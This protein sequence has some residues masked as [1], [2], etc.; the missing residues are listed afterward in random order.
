MSKG[1]FKG[2][3]LLTLA[4]TMVF[5]ATAA[6][7]RDKKGDASDKV[8][9]VTVTVDAKKGKARSVNPA[10]FAVYKGDTKQEIVGVQGPAEAPVNV[11][12]LIQDGLESRVGNELATV[13]E[14]IGELPEG[15]QVMVGYLRSTGLR[16]VQPF[17]TDIKRAQKAIRLPFSNLDQ[18]SAPFI[19]VGE[20]LKTFEGLT[21]RNQV[22]LIS[23]GLELNRDFSSASPA[24]NLDLD[25]AISKAQRLGVP[26]WSIFANAPGRF[27]QLSIV[28]SYGQGSLNRLSDETGGEAFFG[29]TSYVT[30]DHAFD[31]I[32]ENL[33]NQY[34][35]A[36]RGDGKGDLDVTLDTPGVKV[37]HAK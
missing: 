21:G 32:R 36:F 11:A 15:S 2:I 4:S 24:N 29:G 6:S 7:A 8:Q 13:K 20:A 35:I 23:N 17:T 28:V 16:T 22:V 3:A 31:T 27:G 12:I 14:F 5:G 26:V 9:T 37:R 1:I 33:G 30:F 34:L 25:R 10:D 18:G 19:G